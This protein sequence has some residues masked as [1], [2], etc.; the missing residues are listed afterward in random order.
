MQF[1]DLAIIHIRSGSGGAGCV[2]FRKEKYIEFGGPDGGDGGRGGDV[3]IRTTENLN[4]LID[5]K[6]KQHY[7]AK[8]GSQGMGKNKTGAKGSDVILTV[9]VGTEVLLENKQTLLID[10]NKVNQEFLLAGGGNGGWGNQKFKSSTNRAPRNANPGEKGVELTLWLRLKLLADVG[11]IGMPNVGKSSLLAT[12]TNAKPKIG[13]FAFT[14]INPNLGL[15]LHN[16][17]DFVVADIP[18]LIE[19]ANEGKGVGIQFLGHIE[20]CKTLV[21]IIDSTSK[22]L[23]AGYES[24]LNELGKYKE[25]L[26]LK[27]EL[28]ILNKVDLLS[29]KELKKI[30]MLFKEMEINVLP[31]STYSKYGIEDFLNKLV[32]IIETKKFENELVKVGKKWAP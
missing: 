22:D 19:G 26:T 24:T 28:V 32:K 21:H 8:N 29:K 14:T 3:I 31:I 11:L 15:V 2:S 16:Q 17:V 4:T 13:D 6:Y 5:F 25:T 18:G 12:I 7:F 10:L 27:V 23:L 20:R 30:I 9:P 1:I